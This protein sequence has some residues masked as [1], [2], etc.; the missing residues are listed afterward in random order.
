MVHLITGAVHQGK[1]T[2]LL[3]LYR[4][5]Q[6]GDGFYNRPVFRE[7][8]LAGQEIV[9]LAT[10]ASRPFSFRDGFIPQDW[11]EECRY[12]VY[13]FSGAGLKFGREIITRACQNRIEPLFVDEIGPLELAGKGFYG[14][15][16]DLLPKRIDLYLV[17]R[18]GCLD[19]IVTHFGITEYIVID[20]TD[21]QDFQAAVKPEISR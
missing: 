19:E 2:Y 4:S 18:L 20:C 12:H 17:V 8:R 14:L 21:H 1:S 15:V 6:L 13:S 7:G 10:G 3:H 11:D 9:H 16:T 5:L